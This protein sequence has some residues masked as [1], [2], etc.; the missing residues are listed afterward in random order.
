VLNKI[1]IYIHL[2]SFNLIF[3]AS[4]WVDEYVNTKMKKKNTYQITIIKNLDLP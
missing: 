2:N 3:N 1:Y 4:K